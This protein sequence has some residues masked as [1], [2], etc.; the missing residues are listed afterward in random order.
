MNIF[1]HFENLN[2]S[3]D[4][5]NALE[6]IEFFL[7]SDKKVFILQG[8]AGSGKTTILKGLVDH[9][10]STGKRCQLMAPTGRAAKVIM[11]KTG[12]EASTVHYKIYSFEKMEEI[13][14][15]D[16]DSGVMYS[17]KLR[18]N[19]NSLDSVYI[20]DEASMIAN[21]KTNESFIRFG[22]GFLMDDLIRYTNVNDK[23]SFTKIIFVGDP[24]QLPP[25]GMNSSPALD[26]Q[27]ILDRYNINV[28]VAE[29]KE[30]KRQSADNGLFNSVTK[31]RKCLTMGLYN[32]FDLRENGKDIFNLKIEN[33][34]ENYK[35]KTGT[36]IVISFKNDTALCINKMIRKYKYGDN[37][38]IQKGDIIIIGA[39]NYSLG[40]LNGEFGIILNVKAN[41]ITRD[42]PFKKKGGGSSHILLTWLYIEL[43]IPDQ[44]GNDKTIK[45]YML[46]NYLN[47]DNSLRMEEKQALYIDLKQRNP[48]IKIKSEEFAKLLSN[49]PYFNCILLKYG[50]AVT[51]HK[52][53]GGE[54]DSTFIIWDK[55]TNSNFNF[56]TS[57]HNLAGKTNSN[58]YRWAYTAV[59]RTSNQLYC[60]NPPYFNPFTNMLFMDVDIQDYIETL[61][62]QSLKPIEIIIK[63]KQ[64]N[65]LKE[66]NLNDAPINIQDHFLKI[67][68][69]AKQHQINIVSWNRIGY[70]IRYIFKRENATAAVKFWVNGKNEFKNSFL[71]LPSKTNSE[72]LFEEVE[73]IVKNISP[74]VVLRNNV[75]KLPDKTH[76]E[77]TF[78]DEK[79]FLKNLYHFLQIQL[80]KEDILIENI[81]H[82]KYRERYTF[83]KNDKKAV[84]D[85]EYNG[86]GFWG[87]VLPLQNKCN[88]RYIPDKI[89]GIVLKLKENKYVI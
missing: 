50:Y 60:I 21:V 77:I 31:L 81:D 32:D 69:I 2:L 85:F 86:E 75:E 54:W 23:E 84:I 66:Y 89:K 42:V 35:S 79:F 5:H 61:T 43:L 82:K 87:R 9:I 68:Y 33:F 6:K 74:I 10:D 17:F 16:K 8:Y 73:T 29:M 19:I 67:K 56:L 52:A 46:E 25:I 63:E 78:E 26:P 11:Q 47:G 37:L 24:A 28:S 14:P 34:L 22:S 51:C 12:K 62:G 20:V 39:N 58:F 72:A 70:E 36:K 71:K 18:E 48:K 13:K 64:L 27:Y 80:K 1:K 7:S 3:N 83:I 53:Q 57:E 49:D 59:T 38:P 15:E 55:G 41:K 44:K 30:V 40:V 76:M 4:Q 88:S 65:S 45:G